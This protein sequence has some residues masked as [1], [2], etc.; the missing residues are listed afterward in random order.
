M[1]VERKT[2]DI[3]GILKRLLNVVLFLPF[4]RRLQESRTHNTEVKQEEKCQSL[5]FMRYFTYF[6]FLPIPL[7][8]WQ[9][10]SCSAYKEKSFEYFF[11]YCIV[12]T[13][14]QH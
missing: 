1:P 12:E 9:E 5:I 6:F 10:I 13:K 7:V 8:I 11:K 2:T 3:K 14:Y 4:L